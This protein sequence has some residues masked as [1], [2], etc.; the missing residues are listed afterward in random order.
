MLNFEGFGREM[1]GLQKTVVIVQSSYI[2][3]KGFFDLIARADEFILLDDV[4]FTKRDWRNRNIIKT[5]QGLKWL[6]IPVESKG[7]YEQK[8]CETLISDVQWASDHWKSIQHNYA[9]AK[10]FKALKPEIAK[11]FE[12]ISE[13]KSVSRVNRHFIDAVVSR[14]GL[15]AK[16]TW[17]MDYDVPTDDPTQRLIDLTKRTEGSLYL[18]GPSARNYIVPER[19]WNSGLELAYMDYSAYGE[20]SQLHG[21]F[22][23]GVSF[24]DVVFNLGWEGLGEIIS[25]SQKRIPTRD[26]RVPRKQEPTT[27]P[28]EAAL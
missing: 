18:S 9:Q 24:L 8:I 11:L 6:T 2:P 10:H 1:S 21:G 17:S 20:Y 13:E 15:A 22:E 26:L 25:D 27:R 16:I 23:H 3:W 5:P 7:R 28:F 12:E 4:Q 14:L 19:F